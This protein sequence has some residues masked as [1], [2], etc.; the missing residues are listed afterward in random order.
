LVPL[1]YFY[2]LSSLITE[3]VFE[4]FHDL[5]FIF[6]DGGADLLT[7]LMW[8]LDTFYRSLREHTP[9]A[10]EPP[11]SYLRDHV[12][13]IPS[14]FEGPTDPAIAPEWFEMTGKSDLLMFGSHY[15]RWMIAKPD[16]VVPGLTDDQARKIL[17]DNALALYLPEVSAATAPDETTTRRRR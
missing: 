12:R 4:E 16:D 15:P 3:G 14:R 11:T 6:S 7:P 8:R 1:T 17:A 9:W 10:P 5:V 2:H 13:I